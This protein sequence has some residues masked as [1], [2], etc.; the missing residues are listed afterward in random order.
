MLR[1]KITGADGKYV[2]RDEIISLYASDM[3]YVPYIRKSTVDFDATTNLEVPKGPVILHAKLKIPGFGYGMWIMSDNC[4]EGYGVNAEVDFIHDAAASRI[5]EIEE[6]L[7]QTEFA[8][9]VKLCSMLRDA[10]ALLAMGEGSAKAPAYNM[11]SLAAGMWAGELAAVER[12]KKRIAVRGKRENFKF[13]CNGFN[14][15]F[16]GSGSRAMWNSDIVAPKYNGVASMKECYESVFNYATLPFYLQYLEPEYGKPDFSNLDRLL[17]VF[18][19]AGIQTKGHPLWWTHLGHGMPKWTHSLKWED[20]SIK[21]EIDRTIH[22]TVE[23]YK[24]RIHYYDAINECHDWCNAYGLTQGQQAEMTKYCCD[25]IHDIDPT[26]AAVINT[27]FMFG[28]NAADGRTQWGPTWE[29]NLVPY[30]YLEKLDEIGAKYEAIGMQLYNPARDMLAIDKL[31][32]RFDKFN[33][34]I[35]LTE[36]GVPSFPSETKPDTTPGDIYCLEYMYW[37]L[38]HEIEWNERTQADWVEQFYTVTYAHP[39]VEAITWWSFTDDGYV[40]AAGFTT[41]SFEPKESYYRL[42]ELEKSW[43]FDLGKK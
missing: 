24:G 10:K 11:M 34:P 39:S 33:R 6:I 27:C 31:Y 14:Y 1:I 22:R 12:A 8:P 37:G 9:S 3:D 35:H 21:R 5:H 41:E 13:G 25:A 29:R 7:A 19:K 20:G 36:L 18:E 16:D 4:G 17:A 38:W 40:P 28:E 30:T 32:S 23:R 42:K 43:G 26:A 2:T 15:P